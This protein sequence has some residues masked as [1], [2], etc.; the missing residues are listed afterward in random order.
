MSLAR[1]ILRFLIRQHVPCSVG[2]CCWYEESR[3]T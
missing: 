1:L 3:G 2:L